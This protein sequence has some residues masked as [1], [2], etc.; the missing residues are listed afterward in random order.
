MT[1][2]SGC[3][4]GE[5]V[6]QRV[7]EG[8]HPVRRRETEGAEPPGQGPEGQFRVGDRP[9]PQSRALHE[10]PGQEVLQDLAHARVAG[11]DRDGGRDG[12]GEREGGDGDRQRHGVAGH[13]AAG[14]QDN[15]PGGVGN[16][17]V[18]QQRPANA[19]AST[20]NRVKRR[21]R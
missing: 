13:Q 8:Q 14:R 20:P 4:V 5:P 2:I 9:A 19:T 16:H 11:R 7:T 15:D 10:C 3:T 18:G 6:E 21:K 12:H 1:A 17:A